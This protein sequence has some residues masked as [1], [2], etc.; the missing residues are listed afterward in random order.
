[1]EVVEGLK[2]GD[3]IAVTNLNRLDTGQQVKIAT[4]VPDA[5]KGGGKTGEQGGEKT[6]VKKGRRKAADGKASE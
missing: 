5:E 2:E 6:G 1:M 3:E 4:G